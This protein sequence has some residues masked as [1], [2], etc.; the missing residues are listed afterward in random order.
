MEPSGL[1]SMVSTQLSHLSSIRQGDPRFRD[2]YRY[3]VWHVLRIH[4]FLLWRGYSSNLFYQKLSR[5]RDFRRRWGWPTRLISHAQF[6]KRRPGLRGARPVVLR[7]LFEL[8]RHSGA[9]ALRL[10]GRLESKVLIMDLTRL[11]S[12]RRRDPYGAWGVDSKGLFFGYKLGLLTSEHGVIL[13][14]TLMKANWTEFHVHRGLLRMARETLEL[15][16]EFFDVDVL[17]CD[18]GFDGEPTYRGARQEL[19]AWALCPA[20]RQRDPKAKGARES[21]SRAKYQTPYRYASQLLWEVPAMKRL[22]RKRVGIERVNGQLKDD[23]LRID[24]MPRHR[25]PVAS[26]LARAL[27]KA[28][29]YNSCL[30][31]NAQAAAPMRQ[32]KQEWAA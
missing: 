26:L 18:A 5:E 22:Y 10:A 3:S 23:P 6:K 21:L 9:R 2:G 28:I 30:I 27:G 11:P 31:V 8:L 13:G 15:A 24:Q 14:L 12:D 4:L 25:P 19:D 17:L 7:A 32:V 20:R 16:G 1:W 29:L